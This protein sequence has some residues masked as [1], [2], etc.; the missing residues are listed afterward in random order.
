[1]TVL[2]VTAMAS[3]PWFYDSR[4]ALRNGRRLPIAEATTGLI[5]QQ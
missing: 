3:R 4:K 1:M 5:A 2:I